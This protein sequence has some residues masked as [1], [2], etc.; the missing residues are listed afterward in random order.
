M[1]SRRD[2]L[3]GVGAG[4]GTAVLSAGGFVWRSV[5]GV[6]AYRF[7]QVSAS[8]ND[9]ASDLQCT[10]GQITAT[11]VE[12]PFYTPNTPERRDIRDAGVSSGVLVLSGRVVDPQCRPIA[13]AVLDFWQTDHNGVYDNQG[14]R[15]RGHQYTDAEGRF[16]LVSVRPHSYTA[17]SIFR[18]PHIHVRVQGRETGLLTTQLYLPDAQDSNARDVGYKPSLLV[19]YAGQDGPARHATF[20]FVLARG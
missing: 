16:E 4:A 17:M 10:T 3:V 7:G 13:G 20:D 19:T 9:V 1:I 6:P 14:Y 11:D 8:S 12:G 18:T 5:R 2:L 15:Y